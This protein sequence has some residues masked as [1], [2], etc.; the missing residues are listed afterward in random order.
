[1]DSK[2]LSFGPCLTPTLGFTVKRHD[3]IQTFQP[4]NYWIIQCKLSN[5]PNIGLA[6]QLVGPN[7]PK[8]SVE[9]DRG[10]I[11]DKS[12]AQLFVKLCREHEFAVVSS[13]SSKNKKK[14][15]PVPLCTTE[16][17]KIASRQL[18]IGPSTCMSIAEHLYLAGWISYPR[19]ET[20]A[21]GIGFDILGTLEQHCEQENWGN[22]VASMLNDNTVTRAKR[23]VDQGDHPPIVPTSVAQQSD[24]SGDSWR[25]YDYIARHFIATVAEDCEFSETTT[26]LRIGAEIFYTTTRA[27]INP[28]FTRLFHWQAI[29]DAF[30]LP[31]RVGD[32]LAVV[33]LN[34]GERQTEPPDYLTEAELISLMEKYG[35]GTD[36]SIPMHINSICTRNYCA[37]GNN[38]TLVPTKL[39]ITLVHGYYAIDPDLVLPAIRSNIE[40]S[41]GL[42]AKGVADYRSVVAY[43]LDIFFRKF[44]YFIDCINRMDILMSLHY[45]SLEDTIGRA[46]T[47]CGKCHK[48]MKLIP[49]KP[50]RLYCS[51]CDETYSLPPDGSVKKFMERT[52][53]L[54]GF[55]LV[56]FST[57]GENGINY[58]VCPYC[59]N[60]PPFEDIST[61]M[62]CMSCRNTA[63]KYSPEFIGVTECPE[64]EQC[65]GTLVLDA[66]GGPNWKLI[67]NSCNCIIKFAYKAIKV[68]LTGE[69]CKECQAQT[70]EINFH[71]QF[72]PM[73][74]ENSASTL[75]KGCLFCDTVLSSC[76]E[77]TFGNLRAKRGRGG[78]GRGRRGRRPAMLDKNGK[79]TLFALLQH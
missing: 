57:R 9:W 32:K 41:V 18:G 22:I 53:P 29:D 73:G 20:Q 46:L 75:R 70:F 35:I 15:R 30:S 38:R 76:C 71:K 67:C 36:A 44:S 1:L 62:S 74:K 16:L 3:E 24:L 17:L 68:V 72:N 58:T 39:G 47:K 77:Y 27:V 5:L 14:A 13:I 34:L 42:I 63:C 78:R 40:S 43:S 55:E 11:F 65:G 4:E 25:L 21:Y 49:L 56:L 51:V 66:A 6:E 26:E 2:T 59:Y 52:C 54:D 37:L 12:V 48:W 79:P 28:G 45:S 23:G 10:R 69:E 60:F 61:V 50:M 7:S 8:I 31:L 19:T 33:E 64:H